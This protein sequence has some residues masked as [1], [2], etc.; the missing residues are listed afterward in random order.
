MNLEFEKW[1][2]NQKYTMT[3]IGWVYKWDEIIADSRSLGIK[4]QWGLW[5]KKNKIIT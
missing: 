3:S 4:R 2:Q 5:R 1:L